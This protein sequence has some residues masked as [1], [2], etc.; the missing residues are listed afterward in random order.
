MDACRPGKGR[1]MTRHSGPWRVLDE[2]EISELRRRRREGWKV[3][4][5]AEV[6]GVCVRSVYRYLSDRPTPL[7]ARIASAVTRWGRIYAL[8]L[9]QQETD[10]LAAAIAHLVVLRV[11]ARSAATN[12][13][14]S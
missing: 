8:R 7:Q 10:A 3:R 12:E 13:E 11:A 6:Y 1:V 5:L 4:E 2:Q 14:P 9:S